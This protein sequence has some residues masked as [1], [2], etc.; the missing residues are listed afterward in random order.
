MSAAPMQTAALTALAD[1]AGKWAEADKLCG[2]PHMQDADIRALVNMAERIMREAAAI[3]TD[4]REGLRSKGQILQRIEGPAFRDEASMTYAG[5]AL[6]LSLL[7]D[8]TRE[9]AAA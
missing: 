5:Q 8:L 7:D 9:G 4:V 6:L 2:E 1:A 3:P